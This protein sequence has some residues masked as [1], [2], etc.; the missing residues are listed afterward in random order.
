MGYGGR[1]V[2]RA[3]GVSAVGATANF[4]DS[5]HDTCK[6]VM[7]VGADGRLWGQASAEEIVNLRKSC[8]STMSIQTLGT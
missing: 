2:W 3:M 1:R 5:A 8:M 4:G 6:E 7:G